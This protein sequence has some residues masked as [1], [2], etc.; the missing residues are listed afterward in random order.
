[1]KNLQNCTSIREKEC[2]ETDVNFLLSQ[3][4]GKANLLR[5]VI[6]SGNECF[7]SGTMHDAAV[8]MLMDIE[9]AIYQIQ[10][11]MKGENKSK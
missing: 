4:A 6:D 5:I 2:N 7:C 9:N 10:D 1:M 11:I 3:T 8:V